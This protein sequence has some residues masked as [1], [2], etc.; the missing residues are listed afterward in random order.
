MTTTPSRSEPSVHTLWHPAAE[1]LQPTVIA[2]HGFGANAQD[3]L[4]LAPLLVDGR[5]LMICPQAPLPVQPG[6][7]GYSWYPFTPGGGASEEDVLRAVEL[8]RSFIDEAIARYPVDPERV[9]L[10]GFSQGGGLAY[11]VALSDPSRFRGLAALSTTFAPES[12]DIVAPDGTLSAAASALP[13]LVQHG[14][15]DPMIGIDRAR[16]SVTRLQS[17]QLE[18]EYHEYDMGHGVGPESAGDLSR[19]LSRVLEIE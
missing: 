5:L 8:T 2:L 19:W 6:T 1:G 17:L 9:V 16:D 18:P 14:I 10:L 13:V 4:G 12:A 7:T 11:R 3:L 15:S